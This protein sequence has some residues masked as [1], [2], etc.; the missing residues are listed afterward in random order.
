MF[1]AVHPR[2]RKLSSPIRAA[3]HTFVVL[4]LF[5]PPLPHIGRE[6]RDAPTRNEWR[7]EAFVARDKAIHEHHV[8]AFRAVA[9]WTMI[10]V[11]RRLPRLASMRQHT[12]D[13][14]LYGATR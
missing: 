12:C 7:Q 14:G 1:G 13:A 9:H 4:A 10:S 2:A 3:H 8:V 6:E 11:D 5:A